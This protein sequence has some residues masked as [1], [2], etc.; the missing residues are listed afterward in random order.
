MKD[1]FNEPRFTWPLLK[2]LKIYTAQKKEDTSQISIEEVTDCM[3]LGN[4][5]DLIF[6][7]FLEE[8]LQTVFQLEHLRKSDV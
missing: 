3:R 4:I 5:L 7:L 6:I 2:Y 8:N 1:E